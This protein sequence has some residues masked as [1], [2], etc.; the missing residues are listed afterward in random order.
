MRWDRSRLIPTDCLYCAGKE[1]YVAYNAS[2]PDAREGE[3]RRFQ[4]YSA[5]ND[6]AHGLFSTYF[7]EAWAHDFVYGF[8]FPRATASEGA[9]KAWK[10][11]PKAHQS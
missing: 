8:L 3:L 5:D 1:R 7:S 11:A 2:A 9:G 4:Q 6:P 10:A